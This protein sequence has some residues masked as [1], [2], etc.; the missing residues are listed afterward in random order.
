MK[1]RILLIAAGAVVLSAGLGI[2][3]FANHRDVQLRAS[4]HGL[5]EVPPN[6]SMATGTFRA[7][8]DEAAQTITFTLDY[9]NLTGNPSVAHVHFGPPRVNGG[10]MFFFC[11]G[12][13]KPACPAAA[14][15][16]IM[17]TVAAADVVGP[18]TQGVAAGD[19]AN[20]VRAIRTGNAYANIHS[21]LF[22]AG[23]IRGR[24]F[25]VGFSRDH[26]GDDDRD[27]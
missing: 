20:V 17:G 19:F 18:A 22:P 13:G 21:A 4:L 7:S 8:L 11:G 6:T 26:D 9:R 24:V 10:V 15:G 5:N 25:G 23:E 1:S 27:D 3:A 16:T 2:V 14:S 12:G